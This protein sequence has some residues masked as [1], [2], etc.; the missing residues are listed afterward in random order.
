MNEEN[1]FFEQLKNSLVHSPYNKTV[2]QLAKSL[3]SKKIQ[4]LIHD[5]VASFNTPTKKIGL[6]LIDEY[7]KLAFDKNFWNKKCDELFSEFSNRFEGALK[8]EGY[9][10][11]DKVKINLFMLITLNFVQMI[12]EKKELWKNKLKKKLELKNYELNDIK[13]KLL[14]H[15]PS[16]GAL[17]RVMSEIINDFYKFK[18]IPFEKND[19]VIDIGGHVGSVSIFLAKKYPFL[20]IYAFEPI[21]DNYQLFKKNIKINRVKNVKLFN[22]AITSD[23]RN[24]EMTMHFLYSSYATSNMENLK[25]PGYSSFSVKSTT[26][27]DFFKKNKIKK[28]KLLKIDCEGSEYEILLNTKYLDKIEYLAVELHLNE[29]L[30]KRGYSFEKLF[31]HLK[32]FIT[33]KN[34]SL[35]LTGMTE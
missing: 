17:D 16:S 30:K 26:L 25:L 15:K 7:N 34:I 6:V 9:E 21:R 13:L 10:V 19:V 31:E 18:K 4:N 8:K 12:I 3:D 2:R 5:I 35:V 27:D 32:K 23:G 22:K 11:E 28:C 29:F 24:L 1:F 33:E 14:I 20:K